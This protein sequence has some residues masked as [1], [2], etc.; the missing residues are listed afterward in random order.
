MLFCSAALTAA[1]QTTT[2]TGRVFDGSTGAPMPYVTVVLTGDP[3]G[4]GTMTNQ[5]G[6]YRTST[7]G[8]PGTLQVSFVGYAAR[9]FE[10]RKGISQTINVSLEPQAIELGAAVVRPDKN[11]VNPAKP[12]LDRVIEAKERNRP[13]AAGAVTRIVEEKDADAAIRAIDEVNMGVYA[14][15]GRVLVEELPKL[16]NANAQKEY[17]LTDVLAAFVRRGL[18]VESVELEDLEE[19]LGV[20]MRVASTLS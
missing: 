15:D 3:T 6:I 1:G 9:T 20:N 4:S 12:L 16:S 17:Y 2:V 13:D 18:P 8:R 10:V 7:P 11:A 14:F 5:D 19:S